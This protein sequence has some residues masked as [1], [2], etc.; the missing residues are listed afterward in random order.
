MD[1][2]ALVAPDTVDETDRISTSFSSGCQTTP[3]LQVPVKAKRS[4]ALSNAACLL[5]KETQNKQI[6]IALNN[7]NLSESK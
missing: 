5:N 4:P 2:H 3:L 1:Q 6:N 7:L